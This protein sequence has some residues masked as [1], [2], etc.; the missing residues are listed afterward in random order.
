[1][2]IS[3]VFLDGTA[4]RRVNREYHHQDRVTDVL[5][6]FYPK[7]L[8]Q[9][10]EGEVYLCIPQIRRQAKR[11]SSPFADEYMRV[12]IHGL[13]HLQGYDHKTTRER[14]D[15]NMLATEIFLRAKKKR[16]C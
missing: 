8:H 14:K 10:N 5:S 2:D 9:K 7:A 11:A 12:L 4:M 6:F 13:L 3:I 15:M 1:M 16:L